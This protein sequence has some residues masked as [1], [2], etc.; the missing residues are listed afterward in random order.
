MPRDDVKQF[1]VEDAQLLFRNFEGKEKQYNVKGNRNF[2]VILTQ[3]AG[4]AMLEDGWSVNYLK[5]REEGD[6][7]VPYI[8]VNVSFKNK[9]PRVVIMTETS[10]KNLDEDSVE[11]LDWADIEKADLI[12]NGFEWDVN[13][14][15][16]RKAYLKSLFVT[17]AED[18]LEKKYAINDMEE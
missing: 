2:A 17:L 15:T 16:G 18:D 9:P 6:E 4:T 5:P 11:M 3:E 12:C 8:S 7:A 14:K 13:G 1:M 10:R